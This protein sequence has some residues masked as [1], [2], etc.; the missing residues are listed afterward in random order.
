MRSL[1]WGI[2][3]REIVLK[4]LVEI[5]EALLE[6]KPKLTP[7][8]QICRQVEESLHEIDVALKGQDLSRLP[9]DVRVD[10]SQL[11]VEGSR[12]SGRV[13][14]TDNSKVYD[15]SLER[16]KV[17]NCNSSSGG[18]SQLEWMRMQPTKEK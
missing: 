6:V 14:M 15:V 4:R 12:L 1:L 11:K 17:V 5:R 13:L 7:G 18:A 9:K 16:D 3:V 10:T 8:S 2:V